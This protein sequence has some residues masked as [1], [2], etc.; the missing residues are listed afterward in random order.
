MR[1]R[2]PLPFRPAR[3]HAP[4]LPP[5]WRYAERHDALWVD[6]V[7]AIGGRLIFG[8]YKSLNKSLTHVVGPRV[9]TPHGEYSQVVVKRKDFK[10]Y[11]PAESSSLPEPNPITLSS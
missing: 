2:A 3:T 5:G 10:N 7:L 1:Y 4:A 6:S 8:V 11:Q 9:I